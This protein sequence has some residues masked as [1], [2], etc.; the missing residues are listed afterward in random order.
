MTGI[1]PAKESS[2]LFMASQIA[3]SCYK[4]LQIAQQQFGPLRILQEL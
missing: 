4:P 2:E 1:Q 3:G